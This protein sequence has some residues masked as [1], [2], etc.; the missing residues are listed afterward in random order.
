LG[1]LHTDTDT[2]NKASMVDGV[3]AETLKLAIYAPGSPYGK[4]LLLELINKIWTTKC[5]P[6]QW[7][8]S[9]VVSILKTWEVTVMDN[10]RGISK[11]ILPALNTAI[12]SKY[13]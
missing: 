8:S 1:V 2:D 12:K 11:N 7:C 4:S 9:A 13:Y 6:R 10:Y 3:T 5:V